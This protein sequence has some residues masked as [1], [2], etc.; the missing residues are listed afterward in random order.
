MNHIP[1]VL[2]EE[3]MKIKDGFILKKIGRGYVVV[4]VGKA[5]EEFN[6]MIRLNPAGAFL[7]KAV[8]QGASTKE[9]LVKSML[10]YY[11]D[12]SAETAQQDL[13]EFLETVG[14]AM[15]AE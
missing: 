7:W 14:F 6:G 2:K 13:D 3:R 4:A 12:L 10:D 8:M 11:D 5:G 9:Q 1:E 15:E